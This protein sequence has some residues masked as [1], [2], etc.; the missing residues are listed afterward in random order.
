MMKIVNCEMSVDSTRIVVT[1]TTDTNNSE[2]YFIPWNVSSLEEFLFYFCPEC[3]VRIHCKEKF[4]SHALNQHPKNTKTHNAELC[5][6][7]GQ[8]FFNKTSMEMHVFTVHGDEKNDVE[9]NDFEKNEFELP[10]LLPKE[11]KKEDEIRAIAKENEQL[12]EEI[13]AKNEKIEII[14]NNTSLPPEN[15]TN[16]KIENLN[17]EKNLHE[18]DAFDTVDTGIESETDMDSPEPVNDGSKSLDPQLG[19]FELKKKSLDH[20][21]GVKSL[22]SNLRKNESIILVSNNIDARSSDVQIKDEI[23]KTG[24]IIGPDHLSSYKMKINKRQ[25]LKVL[26]PC[27]YNLLSTKLNRPF[28]EVFSFFL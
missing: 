20:E 2:N 7:C 9:K 13:K 5:E 10:I 24:N 3:D 16:S 21:A 6:S 11:S 19:A 25:K 17:L 18:D 28:L 26:K 8:S 12:K 23:D 27:L 22:N 1:R 4:V 14:M 15:F